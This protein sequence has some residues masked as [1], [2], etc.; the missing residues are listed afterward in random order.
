[1]SAI[2]DL[3]DRTIV[4]YLRRHPA[5]TVGDM[6]EFTGVTATAVRQRLVRLM[7]QGL[8]ARESEVVG[9][10]RPTH[11]YSLTPAGVRSGANNYDQLV[12]VLWNEIREIRD[13]EVRRGLL[14]RISERLADHY[15]NEVHGET[16]QERMADLARLMASQDMPFELQESEQ[17]PVLT[18]LACPYPDL[19]EQDRGICA[20]EK[21][22]LSSVLGES[23]RL[24]SCRL[25]GANC[26]TFEASG[27]AG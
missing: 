1:M 19:A 5:A 25:D 12:Q 27:A 15:R 20:M 26:C 3:S 17:L 13:I 6:V 4:D 18:A 14:K 9:R 24:S 23:V 16:L 10:G 7:E 8:L 21:M 2:T 11:R 22:L